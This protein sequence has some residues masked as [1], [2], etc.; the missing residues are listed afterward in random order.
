[1][2]R[3]SGREG[4]VFLISCCPPLSGSVP[5]THVPTL[6]SP[7]PPKHT[8]SGQ[9]SI[10]VRMLT[11]GSSILTMAD[12]ACMHPEM[13]FE[14]SGMGEIKEVGGRGVRERSKGRQEG[15]NGWERGER[16]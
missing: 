4:D 5:T 6:P 2:S 7:Y 16:N 10:L 9:I 11:W 14:A 13:N 8:L 12:R 15:G 1:M 3:V